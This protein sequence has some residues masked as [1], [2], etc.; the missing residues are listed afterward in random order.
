MYKDATGKYTTNITNITE[1]TYNGI[2]C[3]NKE[4]DEFPDDEFINKYA[5]VLL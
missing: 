3:A 1:N 4:H 5:A 2:M